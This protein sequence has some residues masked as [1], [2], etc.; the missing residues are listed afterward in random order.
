MRARGRA[1]CKTLSL[2]FMPPEL[3]RVSAGAWLLRL[4]AGWSGALNAA[5][6]RRRN[7]DFQ[8]E[9]YVWRRRADGA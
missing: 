9:R 6:A 7:C 8:M 1:R 5:Y 2:G 3:A 4:A